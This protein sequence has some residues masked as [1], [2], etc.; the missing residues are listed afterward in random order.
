[1]AASV[2][3]VFNS[4]AFGMV[5]LTEGIDKLPYVPGRIGGMN[6]FRTEGV[7]N[8]T[9]KIEERRGKLTLV[10][11]GARGAMP[12]YDT[13]RTRT[14][15]L[16]EVPHLPKNDAIMADDVANIRQ[17][18]S[19]GKMEAVSTLV[20]DKL[21][22]LKADQGATWEWH[23]A[24]CLSGQIL[25]AD[26]TVVTD[27]FTQFGITKKVLTISAVDL[28]GPKTVAMQARRH[29]IDAL[30]GESFTGMHAFCNEGFM[31]LF[32]AHIGVKEAYA[33]WQDGQFLREQ[34]AYNSVDIHGIMWEEYRNV[35]SVESGLTV[36]DIAYIEHPTV[37]GDPIAY[38]F[39]IGTRNVFKRYNA[40]APF[41][42]TVNTKGRDIYVKQTRDKWNTRV[43]LHTNS[44]PMFVTQRPACIVEVRMGA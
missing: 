12:E 1:M 8:T 40:P 28:D 16:F 35:R 22:Q 39:P 38:V 34:Q 23:M 36:T 6:L 24:K 42:E 5:S 26:G 2:L 4:N 11:I 17:F 7:F 32:A 30:G 27:W 9:V 25:D 10:P 43:D 29:I 14:A 19:A 37:P 41:I 44:N 21:E 15:K 33:R 3:D 31:D 20:A 13:A 18:N